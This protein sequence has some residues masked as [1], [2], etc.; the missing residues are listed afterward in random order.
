MAKLTKC[1]T[2]TTTTER[3]VNECVEIKPKRKA[4]A[5]QNGGESPGIKLPTRRLSLLKPTAALDNPYNEAARSN[6]SHHAREAVERSNTTQINLRQSVK[7]LK[8][9]VK[10]SDH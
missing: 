8:K 6:R 5:P 9:V 10:R 7:S 3:N 1:R 2:T 4:Y